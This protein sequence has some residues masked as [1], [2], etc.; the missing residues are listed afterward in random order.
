MLAIGIKVANQLI[1]K[2]KDFLRFSVQFSSV[3]QS[4]PTLWDPMDCS[5]RGLPVHH[6]LPKFTETHV[7]WVS[8]AIQPSHPLLSPSPPAFNLSQHQ[9]LYII[10]SSSSPVGTKLPTP[11]PATRWRLITSGWAQDSLNIAL[12]CHH[13]L[14][15]KKICTRWEMIKTDAFPQM[16]NEN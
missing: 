6:Q 16:V 2:Q 9:G 3:S 5:T 14:V 11:P 7:H 13:Q 10:I 4:C 12:L 15:K 1:L 8:D